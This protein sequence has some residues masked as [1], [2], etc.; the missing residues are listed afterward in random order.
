MEFG[1]KEPSEPKGESEMMNENEYIDMC[2]EYA[3]K[4][5]WVNP[6]QKDILI[7]EYLKPIYNKYIEVIN[8]VKSEISAE[9]DA[10]ELLKTLIKRLNHILERTRRIG[11]TDHNNIIRSIYDYRNRFCQSDDYVEYAATSFGDFISELL[12]SKS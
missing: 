6:E 12:Y 1:K 8:E 5:G 3:L 2:V 4:T 9:K 7:E 11:S 10:A